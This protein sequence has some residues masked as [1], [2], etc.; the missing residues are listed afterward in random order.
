M[1]AMTFGDNTMKSLKRGVSLQIRER[2]STTYHLGDR[3]PVSRRSGTYQRILRVNKHTSIS[4]KFCVS[5]AR[6][7]AEPA[8]S[9]DV[10]G[11]A[12]CSQKATKGHDINRSLYLLLRHI[13]Q[14]PKKRVLPASEEGEACRTSKACWW[15][16]LNVA[17]LLTR[18]SFLHAKLLPNITTWKFCTVSGSKFAEIL[19]NDYASTHDSIKSVPEALPDSPA[20]CL[21]SEAGNSK[22]DNDQT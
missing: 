3:W 20:R 13:N 4:P 19:Q 21:N 15:S 9:D 11:R 17:A 6:R 10:P 8:P 18:S 7:R 22:G 2:R 16:C 12:G 14:I 5:A 1:P